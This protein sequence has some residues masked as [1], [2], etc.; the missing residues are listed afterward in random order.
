MYRHINGIVFALLMGM[1]AA[2]GGGD[3]GADA[4]TKTDAATLDD[5]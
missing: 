5:A 2:C 3:T 1:L 4:S